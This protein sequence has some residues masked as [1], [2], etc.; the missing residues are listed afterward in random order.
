MQIFDSTDD[1]PT[2]LTTDDVD[3]G[4]YWIVREFDENSNPI[5]SQAWVWFGDHFEGFPM[6]TQG[7]AGPVPIVTFSIDLLD[8]D[9]DVDSYVVKTGDD[10]HPS[11]KLYIKAPK[12]P[13]GP[14]TNIA[15]APDVDMTPPP[16]TGDTLVWNAVDSKWHPSTTSGF[17]PKFYTMPEAA[18]SNQGLA[19]GTTVPLGT[20]LVP[21][22]EW[23]CIPVVHGHVRITGIELDSDPFIVGAEVRLGGSHGVV[24]ARGFGN[25]S[26]Y[27]NI[28]PHAS[29][30][31][32][33]N[34]AITSENGRAVIPAGS[35]GPA[36]T[37][38]IN[39][40][41]DGAFGAYTF[42]KRGAQLSVLLIP[43]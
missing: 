1:L 4:K 10:F 37:L 19:I 18:F 25:I 24:V 15:D 39:A 41:N 9:G 13:Q 3:V 29:T 35:T 38:Y 34:D 26:T 20:M 31:S 43:V 27:V 21:P 8:P 17:V 5:F 7:P 2:N 14:A 6:G 28:T 33:P 36:A 30:S 23:D 32:T 11:L 22:Q 42:M 40:F 16:T 12:G